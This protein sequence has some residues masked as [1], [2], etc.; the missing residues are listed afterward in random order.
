MKNKEIMRQQCINLM[1]GIFLTLLYSEASH[2][3]DVIPLTNP[4]FEDVPKQSQPPRGWGNCGFPLE[5]PT[6]VH[7]ASDSISFWQVTQPASDGDTYLGMVV[8]DNETYE[9]ISQYLPAPLRAGTCYE[10]E[11]S[12]CRSKIYISQSRM[13]GR[14]ENYD[15]PVVFRIYG[16]TAICE[17]SELLYVSPPV[18]NFDWDIYS[19]EMKPSGQYRTI[20][21][22]AYYKTP[23][24]F[25]YN[26]NLLVDHAS[27]IRRVTCPEE[28]AKLDK[29]D[30]PTDTHPQ[31]AHRKSAT[32]TLK[33]AESKRNT[34]SQNLPKKKYIQPSIMPELQI[35]KVKKDQTIRVRSLHFDADSTNI[36][37]ESQ[38]VID[39]I[40]RFLDY[41]PK[42]KIE[43]GGHA[44]L[45]P[46]KEYAR[47]LSQKR[48][49]SVRDYLIKKGIEKDRVVPVGYGNTKPIVESVNRIA[50]KLN[51]RVEIKILE[52][53]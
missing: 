47:D 26:G 43:I 40:Y 27:N 31:S 29:S 48:A 8:R 17:R 15:E 25:P 32:S 19:V 2:A 12:L 44:N 42:V 46:K 20:T 28:I 24:L 13:T 45:M 22:E 37:S 38:Q 1:I 21:L 30:R 11:I 53:Y 49:E 39:E 35:D 50:N 51:Q 52:K 14:T 36:S 9:S 4:S 41:Y 18:S 16:G 33:N 5:S 34:S 23:V 3:Q 10:M 7:P 6:D